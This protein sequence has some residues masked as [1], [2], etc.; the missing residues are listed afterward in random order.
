MRDL[1]LVRAA[2]ERAR[3]QLLARQQPAGWWKGELETNVTID[4][5]DLLMRE[6]L[7]IRTR[8]E[9]ALAANWIR[10]KQRGDGSWANYYGG[11]ADLSTTIEAYAALRL[12]GDPPEAEHMKGAREVA[13]A[14]GGIEHARVFTRI[15]L[16]LFG[17]WRWDDLPAL[18]PELI[19]LPPWFPLNVYDFACWARQTIVPLLIVGAHR[20]VRP[21]PF[22]LAELR[23]GARREVAHPLSSWKGRVQRLDRALQ[24]YERHPIRPLRRL[25]LRVAAEWILARQEADGSWGGIQP[26][27]VYSILALH[28]EGYPLDHPAL[29]RALDGFARFTIEEG[30]HRRLEACQSPVWDTALAMIALRDAGFAPDHPA[31]VRAARSARITRAVSSMSG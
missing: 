2:I 15:W 10:G 7:G 18:P 21:L 3:A 30:D 5:E 29:R 27:W 22:S 19:L 9:T 8:E 11:P 14:L 6:F 25:A 16:A 24:W 28:L 4:A 31:L 17:E 20:P 12:A 23:G 26:P 1:D 13:L